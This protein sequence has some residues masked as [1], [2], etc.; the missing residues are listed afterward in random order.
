MPT[1]CIIIGVE[2]VF[3]C[4]LDLTY[5]RPRAYLPRRGQ[6]SYRRYADRLACRRSAPAASKTAVVKKRQQKL[7][8]TGTRR[9]TQ[10]SY[11]N[12]DSLR[13]GQ[14]L[15]HR[16]GVNSCLLV[17]LRPAMQQITDRFT[18]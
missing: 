5:G 10:I 11:V 17:S 14:T 7:T 8:S 4:T 3:H 16:S 15:I 12:N 18:R 2:I 13:Q 6:G 9:H 1:A